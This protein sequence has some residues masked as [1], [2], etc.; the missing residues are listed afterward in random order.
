M[1][2]PEEER[3]QNLGRESHEARAKC[4]KF[5]KRNFTRNWVAFPQKN[6][7]YGRFFEQNQ[8]KSTRKLMNNSEW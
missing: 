5:E 6:E 1:S 8:I 4:D 3:H 7:G 2:N